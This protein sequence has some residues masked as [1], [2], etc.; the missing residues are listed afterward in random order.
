MGRVGLWFRSGGCR[1]PTIL[2]RLLVA[3]VQPVKVG[4]VIVVA[5]GMQGYPSEG[6]ASSA[7]CLPVRHSPAVHPMYKVPRTGGVPMVRMSGVGRLRR[8]CWKC[9]PVPSLSFVSLVRRGD[10][11]CGCPIR[12]WHPGIPC[13]LPMEPP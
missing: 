9:D 10:G 6:F 4:I 13:C 7:A 1:V 5:H 11:H 12:P 8:S 3:A 2:V